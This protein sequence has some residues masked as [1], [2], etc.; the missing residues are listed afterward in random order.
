MIHLEKKIKE[1]KIKCDKKI[2][3]IFIS[4]KNDENSTLMH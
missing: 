1:F 3:R 4:F 2:K